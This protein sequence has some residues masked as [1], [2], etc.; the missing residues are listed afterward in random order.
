MDQ[1]QL[2]EREA[3]CK[4]ENPPGCTARCPVHVDVRG[5]VSA[6]RQGD[7]AAGFSLLQ[8]RVFFPR[9]ISSICDHPCQKA[10]RRV[11]IDEAIFIHALEKVCV[12]Q[13]YHTADKMIQQ[14]LKNKT[15]AVI[16]AGLSGLT[17]AVELAYKGYKVVVFEAT[18]G[19]GGNIRR[20]PESKLPKQWIE[21]DF[22]ILKK[23]PITIQY[24]TPVS[25]TS[26]GVQK[27]DNLCEKFDALYL[28]VGC[29][30]IE[31]LNLGLKRQSDG[32]L[33]V[34]ELTLATSHAKVFAGGSLRR[35]REHLSPIHSISD[36]KIAAISIERYLQNASL[37]ASRPQAGAVET[38]LYVNLAGIKPESQ[39]TMEKEGGYSE[40]EGL[41]EAQRCLLCEC[42]ECVKACEYLAHYQSYPKRY[43][44]EVY[45]NSS[46]VMGI[47]HANKM[48]NSCSLC[49]LCEQICPNGF[50]MGEVC[51]EARQNMVQTGKMPPSA[52]DFA[53]RD[54][55][56]SNSERFML[57][58]HQ[59]GFTAS[60]TAFF[61]SCQLAASSPQTVQK[62]Y[63][64][65]CNTIP[66]GVA[67]MLGCCGAPAK[68]AGQEALFQET[69]ESVE[70]HW[71]EL[72]SPHVITACPTCFHVFK[73]YLPNVPVEHLVSRLDQMDIPK[74]QGIAV[75]PQKLAVHDSCMTRKERQLQ[76]SVR[77][78]LVK[79]GH[80]VE[81]LLYHGDHTV[82]CGYGG[83][84]IYANPEVAQKVIRRRI[85]E[86]ETDYLTYC[87]MC[88]E[89]FISQGKAAYHLL[90]LI[91]GTEPHHVVKQQVTNYS[92]RQYNRAR[93][94]RNVLREIWNEIIEEPQSEVKVI[95][96]DTVKQMMQ[97]RMILVEDVIK[98]IS[99]A[100]NTGR[101]LKNTENGH[102]IAYLQ[103][104]NVT[105]WVEYFPQDDAFVVYHAYCHRLEIS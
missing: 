47:H 69:I 50:N 39:T 29:Q 46:I 20:F 40:A 102:Y 94:K 66:G 51:Y 7:Y 44:R 57:N 70:N 61:P 103:L 1:Q 104:E 91:F 96:D 72:G 2:H 54:M 8:R 93:L 22:S 52:H 105:Y 18:E 31:R 13:A 55:K 25:N 37:T 48:I 64:F 23:L 75:V 80:S 15:V 45:N 12:Q 77:N 59:P 86:S 58:K 53:L 21:D 62:I 17:V 24:H 42:R 76:D 36:G 34:E 89:N 87:A 27:F 41:Q 14:P 26:E 10:C 49:G 6:I 98:V 43:V 60:K 9:I 28:G 79:L 11:E 68:W 100:E 30:N 83:L 90:D 81:E 73:N 3:R 99:Q 92:E 88:Q 32:K 97:D 67:L 63:E 38:E 84:M 33:D 74:N 19:L 82:C 85:S 5:I 78:I 35:D 101:K 56:F 71:R 95:M 4:Q 16:G 65:L